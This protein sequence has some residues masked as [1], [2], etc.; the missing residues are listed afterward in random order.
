IRLLF[1]RFYF[2]SSNLVELRRMQ[3]QTL[4]LYGEKALHQSERF[5]AGFRSSEVETGQWKTKSELVDHL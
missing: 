4:T 2:T 5:V 1:E 3:P